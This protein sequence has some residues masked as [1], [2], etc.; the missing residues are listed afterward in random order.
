MRLAE[1][2]LRWAIVTNP[3]GQL[4]DVASRDDLERA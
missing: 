1:R 2:K 4:L 3:E